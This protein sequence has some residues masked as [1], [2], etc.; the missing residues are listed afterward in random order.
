MSAN[1]PGA[2][3]VSTTNKAVAFDSRGPTSRPRA[4]Y[5]IARPAA[6]GPQAAPGSAR[7]TKRRPRV[8][9]AFMRQS[10]RVASTAPSGAENRST[11]AGPGARRSVSTGAWSH[12]ARRDVHG[13]DRDRAREGP[14]AP[15]VP[16]VAPSRPV[17]RRGHVAEQT[18]RIPVVVRLP[19]SAVLERAPA[20]RRPHFIQLPDEVA[21]LVARAVGLD[22][23]LDKQRAGE[24]ALVQ[25]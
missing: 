23:V 20:A 13:V 12:A 25:R 22:E 10:V 17:A 8:V 3:V 18:L 16:H 4:L 6:A 11:T 24:A 19:P 5:F 7:K 1:L 9:D 15:V 2:R 14:V 21:E